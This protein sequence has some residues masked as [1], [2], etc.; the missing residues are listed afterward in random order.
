MTANF[1]WI[2]NLGAERELEGRPL[3][4]AMEVRLA[5]ARE[6]LAASLLGKGDALVSTES[7]L[8][9]TQLKLASIKCALPRAFCPTPNAVNTFA[10]LGLKLETPGLSILRHA[11]SRAF[12]AAR[13]DLKG[14]VFFDKGTSAD[15]VMERALDS[16][17]LLKANLSFAGSDQR[18][19]RQVE[20][21]SSAA[22][23]RA[24]ITRVLRRGGLVAEPYVNIE[25]EAGTPAFVSKDGAVTVGHPVEQWCHRGRWL[26]S[27]RMADEGIVRKLQEATLEIGNALS[28][29]GYFGPF[30]VDAHRSVERG[31]TK[32]S[33]VNAR[34]SM[35]WAHGFSHLPLDERP[36]RLARNR[37]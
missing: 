15:V 23:H 30:N 1:F 12:S 36:D 27:G 5:Q 32:V 11:N 20:G 26:R 3:G 19:L 14:V 29:I 8:N 2:L 9:Q 10:S 24:W 16:D 6:V 13:S 33:E 4:A 34:Y 22:K 25:R 17:T 28:S 31:W 18:I 35:G 7:N 37:A 21:D